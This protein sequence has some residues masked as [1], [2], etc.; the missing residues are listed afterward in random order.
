MTSVTSGKGSRQLGIL[1]GTFDP[2]HIGHVRAAVRARHALGL[3]VVLLVPAGDPWQK[4][5]DRAITS[6][7]VRWEMTQAAVAGI[8]GLEAA[9]LEIRRPGPSYTVDTVA[10]LRAAEPDVGI[11]L[12]L[13]SDAAALIP[14]WER[15]DELLS[16]VRIAVVPRP[17]AAV[18][19]ALPGADV[20]T[21]DVEE[22]DVSSSRL[23]ADVVAGRP[24][25]VLVAP[26]VAGLIERHRLYRS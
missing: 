24:L 9:D 26:G 25:D 7:G 20:V 23:R 21:V 3:D 1:G 6:A 16:Q 4:R 11:T 18:P 17:G 22:L 5:G 2:P 14:T 15:P 8:A 13:G 19:V 12:V 10:E